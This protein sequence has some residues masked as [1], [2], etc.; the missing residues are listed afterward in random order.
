M[1]TISVHKVTEQEYSTWRCRVGLALHGPKNVSHESFC[2]FKHAAMNGVL[3]RDSALVR[4]YWAGD[5]L[6]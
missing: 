2:F 6:G 1:W 4:L 3:G 5:N